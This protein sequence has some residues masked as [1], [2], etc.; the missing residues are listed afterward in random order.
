MLNK[1]GQ[2]PLDIAIQETTSTVSLAK[3]MKVLKADQI[4]ESKKKRIE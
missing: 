4:V 1:F 2:T 3:S